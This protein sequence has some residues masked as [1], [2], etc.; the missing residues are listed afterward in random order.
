MSN[1]SFSSNENKGLLWNLMFESGVF[2][3]IPGSQ[4]PRVKAILDGEISALEGK[5]GSVLDKNKAVVSN[6]V[7]KLE[8][9]RSRQA[10]QPASAPQS[11]PRSAI[12]ADEISQQRQNTFTRNLEERQKEFT[13]L[14]TT[15][16]P[17]APEFSDASV[18]KPI[19]SEM[20]QMVAEAMARRARDIE[21]VITSQD[22][23]AAEKWLASASTSTDAAASSNSADAHA[24]TPSRSD[25]RLTIGERMPSPSSTPI[26]QRHV[27]FDDAP[28]TLHAQED[29]L[30]GSEL[31]QRFKKTSDGTEEVIADIKRLVTEIEERSSQVRGLLSKLELARK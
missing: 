12:T 13:S 5:P 21:Q 4:V 8:P 19:G 17:D 10:E 28:V 11:A 20:D 18:D 22:R 27:T 30:E 25:I 9:L 2:H 15:K 16:T 23:T 6:V 14:L 24:D 1:V 26:T 29:E 3:D 31:F 7:K